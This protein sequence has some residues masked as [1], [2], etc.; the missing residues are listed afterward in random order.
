MDHSR[1]IYHFKGCLLGGAVGDALGA[2][3]EF[4]SLNQ[5]RSAYGQQGLTD[6]APAYGR[7]GAITDD[8][9]M[10]LFTTEGLILSGARHEYAQKDMVVTAVYHAYLRWLYTQKVNLQK[11]LINDYGTC[12]IIDGILTG[13]KELFSQRAP[14]KTCMSALRSGKMGTIDNPINNSKG[15]G[16]VMRIAPVGLFY[17]DADKA[18]MI[19]CKCAA[20]THG[21]PSGY[22][23]SGVMA[24]IISMI[25]SGDSLQDAV[26]ASIRILKTQKNH[27]ESLRAIEYAVEMSHKG[28]QSPEIIEKIGAGW[29]AEE[30]LAISLYCALTAGDDF[31]K[32]VLLAVNHSGDS[33]STGSITGNIIGALY[34]IDTIPNNWLKGLEIKDLIE[35]I[36]VDLY[37]QFEKTDLL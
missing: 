32:G 27:E 35:E 6:Y 34:G 4:L 9:Q 33:D 10:L 28:D 26:A 19:G 24:S 30:A 29:V 20:I 21:H 25:I 15:C 37:D 23:A 12:S 5:I 8:T 11:Q 2:A 13:H 7:K 3:I 36:A 17:K 16:G 14:G 31:R 22:L 1:T 18:F